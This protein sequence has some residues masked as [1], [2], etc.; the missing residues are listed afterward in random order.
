MTTPWL[1]RFGLIAAPLLLVLMAVAATSVGAQRRPGASEPSPVTVR[2]PVQP[3][4]QGFA[5]E[6]A[7]RSCHRAELTEFHKT[8]HARVTGAG[9]TQRMDCESCHGPGKAHAEAQE[10][11]RGDE[12]LGAAANRLIFS[13]KG[14]PAEN[15][16]RC[17]TCHASAAKLQR[18]D[19]S[20]HA[21]TGV[22]C[23]SCHST[24]LVEAADPSAPERPPLAQAQFF[25]VPQLAVEQRWLRES[26]LKD[27]QPALCFGCHQQARAQFAQPFHHRVPEGSMKCS[28]C[29]SPHGT[30]NQASLTQ[31]AWET[32]T[33]CHTDKHG[34]FVF[35]HAA[36]RVEGCAVCHTPHGGVSRFML[37]RRETRFVC[38][39]CHGDPHSEQV[40]VPHGRLSFQT[41]GDC[42]RCHVAI[43]GSNFSKVFLQ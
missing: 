8:P 23:Q 19:H 40:S 41:R 34:P 31:P 22:S 39:Q 29:H 17:L 16:A 14:T 13:F 15:S 20:R 7:C 1:P 10:A 2:L 35:E 24:H 21:S 4:D 3:A 5:G 12:A 6:D 33:S 25:Q 28:D 42:T 32:C 43:H 36:V 9:T 30:A 11:S 18:F 37:A 27:S 38:L 26:L